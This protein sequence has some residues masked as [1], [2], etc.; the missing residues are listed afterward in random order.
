MRPEQVYQVIAGVGA[1]IIIANISGY[2]GAEVGRLQQPGQEDNVVRGQAIGQMI[3]STASLATASWIARQ[4]GWKLTG[5][6]QAV[7]AGIAL[8]ASGMFLDL[9]GQPPESAEEVPAVRFLATIIP[10]PLFAM[11]KARAKQ[12]A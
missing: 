10:T 11:Q 6:A 7:S 9:F 3:G 12:P 1:T 4:P 2:I 5:I 8:V